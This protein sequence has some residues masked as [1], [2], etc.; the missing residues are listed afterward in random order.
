MA[1]WDE[2]GNPTRAKLDELA[3]GWVGDE[4]GL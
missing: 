2:N 4:L 3:L 1:G